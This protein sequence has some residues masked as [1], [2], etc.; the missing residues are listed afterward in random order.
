M[1]TFFK[2]IILIPVICSFFIAIIFLGMGV[3][4]TS[5]GVKGILMGKIFTDDSPGVMFLEALDGFL[6]GFLFIIFSIGFSQ[7]FVPKPSKI[8]NLVN[9]ITPEWLKVDSFT[10][11]KFILWDTLLTTLF[12]KFLVDVFKSSGENIWQLMTVPVGILLLAISK[13]L[14]ST[15]DK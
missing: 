14:I 1:K 12:V 8:M 11:L 10:Q 9:S 13:Y 7:L 3:Y 15:K 2:L 6:L 5:Q 4:R